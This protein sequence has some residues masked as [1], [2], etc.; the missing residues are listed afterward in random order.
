MSEAQDA[1]S[2]AIYT[3]LSALGVLG[4]AFYQHV[5]E[6]TPPPVHII[7]DI[8]GEPLDDAGGDDERISL[9]I[10]SVFQGEQNKP[11]LVEQGRIKAALHEATLTS[12]AGW[13]IRPLWQSSNAVL[14]PDAET[15][16]GTSTFTVF[17]FAD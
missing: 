4:W 12:V 2:A 8:S 17:A 6:N 16:L 11:V 13:T 14:M 15:Y 1:T 5:P 3:A 7:G 10:S 9:E